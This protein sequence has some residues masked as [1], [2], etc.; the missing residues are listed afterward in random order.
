[1]GASISQFCNLF[2]K[3]GRAFLNFVTFFK[4]KGDHFSILQ[5]FSKNRAIISQ[6][7]DIF[8]KIGRSF[9]SFA[10]FFQKKAE[11]FWNRS[12]V[13]QR[14]FTSVVCSTQTLLKK[15]DFFLVT[16][17]FFLCSGDLFLVTWQFLLFNTRP[18]ILPIVIPYSCWQKF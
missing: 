13:F 12:E 17:K 18:F 5:S 1:M 10:T 2:P 3:K 11:L 4:K 14:R 16:W 8:Q 9:L 7:C 15:R 6:F